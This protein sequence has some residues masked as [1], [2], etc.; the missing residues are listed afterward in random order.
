MSLR[1][2]Q[3]T[4]DAEVTELDD[5]LSVDEDVRRLDVSVDDTM[6]RL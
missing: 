3:A 5:S 4:R 2:D 1:V 6:A